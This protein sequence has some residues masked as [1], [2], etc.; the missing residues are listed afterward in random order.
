M[1]Q[2]AA[3]VLSYHR[4]VFCD[5]IFCDVTI[6]DVRTADASAASAE[7]ADFWM[8]R[9]TADLFYCTRKAAYAN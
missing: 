1:T 3:A 9:L 6:S 5:V 4:A 8:A 7:F 2:L